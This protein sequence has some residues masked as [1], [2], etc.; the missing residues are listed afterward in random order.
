MKF[1][2]K[3]YQ[4][5]ACIF[6]IDHP[7]MIL[8]M[9]CGTGKTLT[10]LCMSAKQPT[11]VVLPPNLIPKWQHEAYQNGFGSNVTFISCHNKIGLQK[12]TYSKKY[13]CVI[14]DESHA[15]LNNASGKTGEKKYEIINLLKK[16]NRVIL[17]TATPIL[18]NPIDL[19]WPLKICGVH[20][21]SKNQFRIMYCD[22]VVSPYDKNR[23]E[24]RGVSNVEQLKK[25]VK[26]ASFIYFR[27][28]K[29]IKK[30][31]YLDSSPI[32]STSKIENFSIE[33][34]IMA[35][36]KATRKEVIDFLRDTLRKYKKIVVFYF[37][38]DVASHL[39]RITQKNSS[40]ITGK[41]PIKTR[42][43]V[44]SEFEKSGE[45]RIL[46]LNYKSCGVGLDIHGIDACVFLE[47]TWSDTSDY[48]SYMRLY[49]FNRLKPLHVYYLLFKNEHKKAVS[50][51]KS[52]VIDLIL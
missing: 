50:D 39:H 6:H 34:S 26:K 5:R 17:L 37:H 2:L 28:E 33:Q 30:N 51:K 8:N 19:Y 14:V 46:Y 42:Y 13:A 47:K 10:A 38:I 35:Y 52:Q 43:K 32:E 36:D 27:D 21:L 15:L 45:Y 23:V 29:V 11:L 48:Q 1:E 22:G 16:I 40:L 31:I 7:K 9:G 24:E 49:R 44:I 20:N 18:N 25:L 3:N 12:A 4:K 41:T